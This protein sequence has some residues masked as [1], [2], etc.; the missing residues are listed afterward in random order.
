MEKSTEESSILPTKALVAISVSLSLLLTVV[1]FSLVIEKRSIKEIDIS[2]HTDFL[3]GEQM[4]EKSNRTLSGTI[5]NVYRDALAIADADHVEISASFMDFVL[6]KPDVRQVAAWFVRACYYQIMQD[7]PRSLGCK[8]TALRQTQPGLPTNSERLRIAGLSRVN[9]Q[10]YAAVEP[11]VKHYTSLYD[12]VRLIGTGLDEQDL[13]VTVGYAH[14]N[15]ALIDNS[16][17]GS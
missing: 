17:T 1:L 5:D 9:G 11:G 15:R 3:R 14:E 6:K 8:T 7:E 13:G 16:W 4:I 2:Q 10:W 12:V